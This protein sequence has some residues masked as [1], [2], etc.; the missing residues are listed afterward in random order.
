MS[1]SAEYAETVK[2][3]AAAVCCRTEEGTVITPENLEDPAI[4]PDLM[5]SGLMNIPDNCLKV[6]E[7]IGAKLTKTIDS[8]TPITPDIV[9]GAKA[10]EN[11]TDVEVTDADEKAVLKYNKNAG[12]VIKSEDLENPMHFEKLIDSLLID[13]NDSVL[14]RGEVVGKK[15]A[16]DV[17]ALTPVT[18]DIIEGFVEKEVPAQEVSSTK[19]STIKGGVVKIKIGEGKNINIEI[20]V[21][22]KGK[23]SVK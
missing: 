12:D 6:G 18:G 23:I 4:F 17:V 3:E 15:L 8:L 13:L 7:V 19:P 10:I 14:T 9:E 2:N 16:K 22:M 5:D 11:A 1:M 20:P 21:G